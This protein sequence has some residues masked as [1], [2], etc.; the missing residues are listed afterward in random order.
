[1]PARDGKEGPSGHGKFPHMSWVPSGAKKTERAKLTG[2]ERTPAHRKALTLYELSQLPAGTPVVL[3]RF[4][5]ESFI[6]SES[7]R[8][9]RIVNVFEL[10]EQYGRNWVV[11]ENPPEHLLRSLRR[12]PSQPRPLYFGVG[13]NAAHFDWSMRRRV[14]PAVDNGYVFH[15]SCIGLAPRSDGKW[16]V[17]WLMRA[18][19]L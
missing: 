9:L 11:I 1:M 2:R 19:D 15:P 14:Q 13:A 7:V 4:N 3:C 18:T 10:D 16:S 17:Y 12:S 5:A 8:V 6:A